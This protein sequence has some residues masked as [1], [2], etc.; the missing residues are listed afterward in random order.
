ML[1]FPVL[2][3]QYI[4]KIFFTFWRH[5]CR[6]IVYFSCMIMLYRICSLNK[7]DL[8]LSLLS[9]ILIRQ[10]IF[11][12]L[13]LAVP[14]GKFNRLTQVLLVGKKF[15]ESATMMRKLGCNLKP[16]SGSFSAPVTNLN[17]LPKVTKPLLPSKRKDEQIQK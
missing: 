6:K 8:V 5:Y 2:V 17:M 15:C 13:K 3:N 4:N 16:W 7:C 9:E 10:N 11:I 12:H 14:L 1:P